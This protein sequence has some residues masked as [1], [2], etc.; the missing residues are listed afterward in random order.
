MLIYSETTFSFVSKAEKFLKDI[1]KSETNIKLAR[2]RFTHCS[3]SC[4]LRIVVFTDSN[5]LGYFD[6]HTHHIA[7]NLKLIYQVKDSV[8]KDILRH[9]FA[10]YITSI[11]NP[12]GDFAAHGPEYKAVCTRY[13]WDKSI[14]KA[15]MNIEL[16]NDSKEGDIASEKIVKKIKSLLKLAESQNIHEAELATLKANQL[17]LKHNIQ[18]LGTDSFNDETPIYSEQIL[19]D[20]RRSAKLSSIYDIMKHFLVSPI[21]IYGKNQVALEVSGSKENIELASYV[22]DFLNEELEKQWDLVKSPTLKGARAKNSF[23]LGVAKGYDQKM[24]DVLKNYTQEEKTSLVLIK[25][26]MQLSLKKIYKSVSH[27][28]SGASL[29]SKAFSS[30]VSKGRE[31]TINQAIKN[32]SKVAQLL[33][34]R[35]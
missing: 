13:G 24:N 10:H 18:K 22:A 4:P 25:N 33:S 32:K 2:S 7:L 8:L 31:L 17:L 35:K 23:F 27:T 1:I 26:Q 16:A 12:A 28:R 19:V 6:P 3:L 30:G 11:E 21:F 34:W 29:D 14:S 15:S 20:K 9:E 5:S